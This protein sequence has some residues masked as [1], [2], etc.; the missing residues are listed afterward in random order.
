MRSVSPMCECTPKT[1][2]KYCGRAGCRDPQARKDAVEPEQVPEPRAI[3]EPAPPNADG[4][5]MCHVRWMVETPGG[6]LGSWDRGA[7]DAYRAPLV[8]EIEQLR[9]TLQLQQASYERERA[10]DEAEIERLRALLD[11]SGV[12]HG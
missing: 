4:Q 10:I 11:A 7:F 12:A 9:Q 6:W 3:T 2:G 5:T 8:E 1:P